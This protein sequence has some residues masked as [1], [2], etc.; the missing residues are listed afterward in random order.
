M[1]FIYLVRFGFQNVGGDIGLITMVTYQRPG[2][3]QHFFFGTIFCILEKAK[4][5]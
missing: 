1:E 3:G 4:S 5:A 2:Y